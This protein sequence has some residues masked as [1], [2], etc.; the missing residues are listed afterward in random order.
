MKRFALFL[1]LSFLLL[2]LLLLLAPAPVTQAATLRFAPA[3]N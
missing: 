3:V 1:T 2:S